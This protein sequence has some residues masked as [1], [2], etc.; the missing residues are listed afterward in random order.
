MKRSGSMVPRV[1]TSRPLAR[2]ALG[3]SALLAAL[4]LLTAGFVVGRSEPGTDQA[5]PKLL[6]SGE[7]ATAT[8]PTGAATPACDR[9]T[10]LGALPP[11]VPEWCQPSLAP[12]ADTAAEGANSWVDDF[13]HGQTHASLSSAYVDG[14]VGDAVEVIHF[15]H[16]EH[17]MADIVGQDDDWPT[18]GAAW[19]RP[20]RTFRPDEGTVVLEYEV[21]GPIAGTREVT[22][23]GDSWP[24]VV[25]TTAP[26]PSALRQNGTYLYESFAGD[27]TFGCRMQQSQHPICAL[28]EPADGHAGG[29]A[30]Q[31][32]INQNG[33]EV[34]FQQG[35]DP[36]VEGLGGV[37]KACTSVEDPDTVCR[38]KFRM[39]L[40]SSEMKLFV[41]G[42][43]YYHAGFIDSGMSNILD[44]PEG[45]YVYFG[46][47]AYRI[48]GG[49]VVRFHWDRIAVNP[50]SPG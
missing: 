40:T 4:T 48:E 39:E 2:A 37:W 14:K 47:F 33:T 38:N 34:A 26:R 20:D 18:M 35:G 3:A 46:D 15:Q 24:E 44:A 31:W 50:P 11:A 5:E 43:P 9:E 36:T 49:V 27:W 13:N 23:L 19:I 8:G 7:A 41:N 25:L 12:G 10:P 17:W 28:Y 45:F 42:T 21:A 1:L 29:P 32:E 16:N 30:R 22:G 6:A